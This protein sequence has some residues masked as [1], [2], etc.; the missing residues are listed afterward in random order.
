MKEWK[1]WTIVSILS[2]AAGLVLAFLGRVLTDTSAWMTGLQIQGVGSLLLSVGVGLFAARWIRAQL[3]PKNAPRKGREEPTSAD[4][5]ERC[6]PDVPAATLDT[7]DGL[8]QLKTWKAA[9]LI[10][11]E[12]YRRRRKEL[13]KKQ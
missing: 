9:G 8:K 3:D 4:R 10:T 11:G 5:G 6:D 1:K 2:I 7:G 12:E 13:L